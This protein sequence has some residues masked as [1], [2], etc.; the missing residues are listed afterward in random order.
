MADAPWRCSQCGTVNEPV[1]NAC[2]RC[3][4]WPSLFDLEASK[5]EADVAIEEYEVGDTEPFE[6]ESLEP[7]VFEV[8]EPEDRPEAVEEGEPPKP[9]WR[10]LG[11]LIVPIAIV[12]YLVI[13]A[14]A[15]R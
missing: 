10:R 8:G 12:L 6:V 9:T 11:S 3:G 15:N 5:I 14:I 13:S 1:A 2:R 7:E 4:R